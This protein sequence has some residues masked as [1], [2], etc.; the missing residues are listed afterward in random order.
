[1]KLEVDG[2]GEVEVLEDKWYTISNYLGHIGG[3]RGT[4]TI[5]IVKIKNTFGE[6]KSYIGITSEDGGNYK[7]DLRTI[8]EAG[9]PYYG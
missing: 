5:G 2:F 6:E 9:V 3:S 4:Y 1:M 8:I 7:Q